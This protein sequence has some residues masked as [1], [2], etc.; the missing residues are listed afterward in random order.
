[1]LQ[2]LNP[3]HLLGGRMPIDQTCQG[4]DRP[5]ADELGLD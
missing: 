1:V 2:T 4:R 3:T 5:L